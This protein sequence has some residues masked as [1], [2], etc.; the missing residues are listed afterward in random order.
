MSEFDELYESRFCPICFVA[1]TVKKTM[2]HGCCTNP[3]CLG[4]MPLIP[5]KNKRSISGVK[6]KCGKC[7][8]S[9]E[10]TIAGTY[11]D[12][13]CP[14]C[15]NELPL[16]Y[17]PLFEATPDEKLKQ[18]IEDLQKDK[19]QILNEMCDQNTKLMAEIQELANAL[20][21]DFGAPLPSELPCEM[22]IRALKEQK[23]T[24]VALTNEI[25]IL[26]SNVHKTKG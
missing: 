25:G 11:R 17:E 10:W 9:I 15:H 12:I 18:Q 13:F 23:R 5:Y 8:W 1:I 21:A 26:R 7:N 24:I 16:I 19:E 4:N 6:T 2:W 14:N 22:A 3:H 20:L